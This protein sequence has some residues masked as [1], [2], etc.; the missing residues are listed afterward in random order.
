M[1]K[2]IVALAVA[3]ILAAPMAAQA[4]VEVYGKARL[5]AGLISN[6]DPN[7]AKEDSKLSITSHASR[8]GFK[9]SEDLGG[10]MKAMWQIE[11]SVDYTDGSSTLGVRNTFVGLGGNFGTVVLGTH[12][13]PYKM[14][15]GSL[16]PFVDTHGDYNSVI[17][18]NQDAR[19]KNVL[20]YLSPD[21]SGFSVAAAIVT[22]YVDD[23]LADTITTSATV[24]RKQG[25]IS[26]A[27]MYKQGPLDASLAYQ[28]MNEGS[29][30][31]AGSKFDDTTAV[32]LGLGY[33]LNAATKVGFVYEN[34][35]MGGNSNDQSNVYVSGSHGLGNGMTANLAIGQ[36]GDVG[37]SSDTGAMFFA[38]GVNKALSDKTEV[39][40]IYSKI[41][42]DNSDSYDL[43]S[44]VGAAGVNGGAASAVA[45][46]INMKFSSM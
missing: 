21:M 2:K 8:L 19:S 12:D 36:K 38:V 23:N 35:D 42:S 22:D 33:A 45:V 26:L 6:D 29:A 28:Q 20:A 25:A 14:A 41:D 11:R 31:M 10:G 1:Q 3:G 27:G 18:S 24:A 34:V 7:P 46:G 13:T 17:D 40:G 43:V 5:S 4:G 32:K 16:D 15:T 37:N 44:G 9:G 30:V 39:Y